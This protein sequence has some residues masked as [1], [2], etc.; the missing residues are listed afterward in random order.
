M[1]FSRQ[2]DNDTQG[3]DEVLILVVNISKDFL[4]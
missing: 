4:S 2:V 1:K 3:T